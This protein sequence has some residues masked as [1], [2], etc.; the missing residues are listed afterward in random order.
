MVRASLRVERRKVGVQVDLRRLDHVVTEP[1]A[2]TQP[3]DPCS[4]SDAA[5]CLRTCGDIC[6]DVG[7]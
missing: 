7:D 1:G 4:S 3:L 2:F 6:I 5:L